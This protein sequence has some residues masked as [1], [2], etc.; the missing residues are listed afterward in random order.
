MNIICE[1]CKETFETD[2]QKRK[3]CSK[4]CGLK[5]RAQKNHDLY[6]EDRICSICGKS[7]HVRKKSK[8]KTCSSKCGNKSSGNKK[9]HKDIERVCEVCENVFKVKMNSK[10]VTCSRKCGNTRSW[11]LVPKDDKRRTDHIELMR[12][13]GKKNIGGDPWNKGVVGAQEAWNKLDRIIYKCKVCHRDYETYVKNDNPRRS[14][15]GSIYCTQAKVPLPKD[16]DVD[17]DNWTEPTKKFRCKI[18]GKEFEVLLGRSGRIK[19]W[20]HKRGKGKKKLL[21]CSED[22]FNVL[23]SML[24]MECGSKSC[25]TKPELE[26]EKRLKE[27]KVRYRKQY[28]QR[29]DKRIVFYDFILWDYNLLLEVDGDYW[30]ANPKIY[31]ILNEAQSKNVK[32][33]KFKERLAKD[34]GFLIFRIWESEIPEKFEKLLELL[35]TLKKER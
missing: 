17:V 28:W 30:H 35:K 4:S 8:K 13:I 14:T 27:H 23:R 3:Y 29:T 34:R 11:S 2:N 19:G 26:V 32:N 24:L 12:N 25:D 18:C 22:C 31:S 33:D 5:H 15:C 10:R 7:F 16:H 21:T 9:R 1:Y 20:K 6:Y